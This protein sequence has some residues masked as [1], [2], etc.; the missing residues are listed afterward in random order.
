MHYFITA[1]AA[2]KKFYPPEAK[3]QEIYTIS[4]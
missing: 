2:W 4:K 1:V 3:M